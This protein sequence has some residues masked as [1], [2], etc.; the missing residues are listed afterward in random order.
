[1]EKA[2]DARIAVDD[3]MTKAQLIAAIEAKEKDEPTGEIVYTEAD[4]ID[5]LKG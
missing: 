1:M 2:E 3:S 5:Q 4:S